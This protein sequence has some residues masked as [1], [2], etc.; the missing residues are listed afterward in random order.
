MKNKKSYMST[1]NIISEGILDKVLTF[2]K[3]YRR[4][5]SVPLTKQE[6]KLLKNPEVK[7]FF[8]QFYKHIQAGNDKMDR[9]SKK[10]GS[11]F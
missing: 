5:K 2:F 9:L 4:K 6:K 1:K 8:N 11:D 7:K 3:L 10:L